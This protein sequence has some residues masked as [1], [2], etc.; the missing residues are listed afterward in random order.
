MVTRFRTAV[1]PAGVTRTGRWQNIL[2]LIGRADGLIKTVVA[3]VAAIGVVLGYFYSPS[4]KEGGQVGWLYVGSRLGDGWYPEHSEPPRTLMVD[5][6]PTP[7]SVQTVA[8]DVFLRTDA[9]AQSAS[10]VKP[11]LASPVL[12]DGRPLALKVGQRVKLDAIRSIEV[13]E[14]PSI[15]RTWIWAHVTVLPP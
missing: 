9:P 10:G 13:R 3:L 5:S 2:D 4:P 6:V 8:H 11:P 7:S 15:A 12:R 14:D 1:Q